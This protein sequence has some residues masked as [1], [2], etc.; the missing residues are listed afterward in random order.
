MIGRVLTRLMSN[1]DVREVISAVRRKHAYI[2]TEYYIYNISD[3][4]TVGSLYYRLELTDKIPLDIRVDPRI[5]ERDYI[6]ETN[7]YIKR[8]D[9]I[10]LVTYHAEWNRYDRK[11]ILYYDKFVKSYKK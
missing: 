9:F 11:V 1:K 5:Y 10:R 2:V 3:I 7:M 8:P 6:P 4:S